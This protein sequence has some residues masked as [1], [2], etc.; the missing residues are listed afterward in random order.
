MDDNVSEPKR[1]LLAEDDAATRELYEEIL[2]NAGFVVNAVSDGEEALNAAR[3]KKYDLILLDMMMP[4]VNGLSFLIELK[5]LP[6]YQSD[7]EPV[8]LFT[9]L[10][11]DPVIA[12]ALRLGAKTYL[13]KSELSPSQLVDR[14]H[15]FLG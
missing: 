15:Y 14:I 13:I 6:L 12:E 10:M 8:V 1:I 4:K 7:P 11:H 2:T 5:K 3:E 9:N